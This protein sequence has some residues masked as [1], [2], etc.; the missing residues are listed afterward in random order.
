MTIYARAGKLYVRCKNEEGGYTRKSLGLDDTKANRER[1]KRE[2]FPKIDELMKKKKREDLDSFLELVLEECECKKANTLNVYTYAVKA[3]RAFFD[4]KRFIGDFSVR[5]CDAFVK[6]LKLF[7]KPATVN[8][9]TTVLSASFKEALR[10]EVIEKNPVLLVKR[11]IRRSEEKQTFTESEMQ[12]MLSF[13]TGE[14]KTFIMI[15]FYTGARIG[16]ILALKWEDF[17]EHKLKIERTM[18][19][20]GVNSPKS[21]KTRIVPVHKHLQEYLSTKKSRGKIFVDFKN[22]GRLREAFY[23]LQEQLGIEKKNVH[24]IRHTTASLLL[25]EKENPMLI[26]AMLGHATLS[27]L[28]NVYGHYIEDKRDLQCFDTFSD[29]HISLNK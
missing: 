10:Q 15:A 7:Y 6:E 18:T 19:P 5:E 25:K 3:I 13:S 2:F 29:T 27:M 1:A 21:G 11:P 4:T 12:K 24:V 26:K 22:T 28:E 20:F 16:E 8:L 17:V 23:K 14:L 9:Y